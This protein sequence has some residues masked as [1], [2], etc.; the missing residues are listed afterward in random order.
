MLT[1]NDAAQLPLA[2]VDWSHF[3]PG[4]RVTLEIRRAHQLE[5]G[6]IGLRAW[7][8]GPRGAFGQRTLL[9]VVE[10]DQ[11]SLT[12]TLGSGVWT[13]RHPLEP[14]AVPPPVGSHL[15][16][17]VGNAATAP[18]PDGA[19]NDLR[20]GDV[21]LVAFQ[22][23][24]LR[25]LGLPSATPVLSEDEDGWAPWLR[26]ALSGPG[27]G[28]LLG[29]C[30]DAL[31]VSVD[32]VDGTRVTVSRRSQRDSRLPRGTSIPV[33]PL[34]MVDGWVVLRA[35]SRLHRCRLDVLLPG[36]PASVAAQALDRLRAAPDLLWLT[37][38]AEGQLSIG[39]PDPSRGEQTEVRVALL[40]G[41]GDGTDAGVLCWDAAG[42]RPRW[43]PATAVGWISP[44]AAE[45]DC[46]VSARALRNREVALALCPDGTLSVVD[47]A[48]NRQRLAQLR[49]GDPLRVEVLDYP[50]VPDADGRLAFLGRVYLTEVLVELRI[51]PDA[52]R[53]EPGRPRFCEVE[54]RLAAGRGAQAYVRV[55]DLGARLMRMAVPD[56]LDNVRDGKVTHGV[57]ERYR[58][59]LMPSG[60]VEV[61][62]ADERIVRLGS[63]A[64]TAESGEEFARELAA[65]V[66][67]WA[68]TSGDQLFGPELDQPLNAVPA[69]AMVVALARLGDEPGPVGPLAGRAAVHACRQLGLRAAVS[70][71]LDPMLDCWLDAAGRPPRSEL[72]RRLDEVTLVGWID[73]AAVDRVRALH[74][75]IRGRTAVRHDP[76][77]RLISSCIAASAGA[78]QDYDDIDRYAGLTGQLNALSRA[79][80]P[81]R[82]ELVSQS[83]LIPAQRKQVAALL[84]ATARSL[85][86]LMPLPPVLQDPGCRREAVTM[87]TRLVK[88]LSELAAYGSHEP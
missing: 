5:I 67:D 72:W 79:L 4:D 44:T 11:E 12:L 62:T 56:W 30:G 46:W 66:L 41:L 87:R 61:R 78:H 49:V 16:L 29:L 42:R 53:P 31:P 25:L 59:H 86:T 51:A 52:V 43:L 33:V 8:P 9:P 81:R 65:A 38:S 3:A 54:C 20:V 1:T 28:Q 40:T 76:D 34:G 74:E 26:D 21:V 60:G 13:V 82:D 45:L 70:R 48:A 80:A 24:R 27:A 10:C 57:F 35:G 19:G 71:H 84:D 77:L 37:C 36:L 23:G 14:D 32:A 69:L 39:L 85:L 47:T 7:R 64:I 68:V 50:G 63:R 22:Q 55:C 15:W 88:L 18:A 75:G 2:D 17:H 58:V 73:P 6:S 83:I